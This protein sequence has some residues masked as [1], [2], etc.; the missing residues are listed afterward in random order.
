MTAAKLLDRLEYVRGN[1]RDRWVAR[2]PAHD[3]RDPSL[4][5]AETTDGRVLIH[6]H[7]GCGAIA[8][9]DAVGLNWGDL[10]S[11]NDNYRPL[12]KKRTDDAIEHAKAI[13]MIC[14][15][16]RKN[17]KKLSS[18]DKQKERE[19]LVLLMRRGAA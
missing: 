1:G 14:E 3:D 9:L 4:S 15:A 10:F 16:D 11:P 6:C 5:I 18:T 12:F 17:G 13:L 8:V 19:A 2:C 7:A